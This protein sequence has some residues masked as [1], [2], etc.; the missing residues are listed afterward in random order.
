MRAE[1]WLSLI[2]Y[3]FGLLAL[4]AAAPAAL[5]A[6]DVIFQD[7]ASHQ[8]D[9]V[10]LNL[11]V[12]NNALYEPTRV[13]MVSPALATYAWVCDTSELTV[14]G[15]SIQGPLRAYHSSQ[16]TVSD[17]SIGDL[18]AYESSQVTVSGG[19]IGGDLLAHE[20]SQ[21][22]VSGG[23][24]DGILWA[25][26]GS[27]VT[28]SGGSIDEHL[29]ADNSSQVTVSGGTIGGIMDIFSTLTV[30][31]SDFIIDGHP[32]GVGTYTRIDERDPLGGVL[33]GTFP[34]GEAFT[35]HFFIYGD[36]QLVLTPEPATLSLLALGGLG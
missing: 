30:V 5:A 23:S 24:I 14:S 19:S 28:V 33:S 17:G 31:G 25:Q 7:G 8:F 13:E 35:N 3:G 4:L 32:V 16:V 29:L 6:D 22:T 36:G 15:G 11:V 2:C 9:G 21:V 34:G 26:G 10:C 1:G 20:S 12:E 18:L 27:Q